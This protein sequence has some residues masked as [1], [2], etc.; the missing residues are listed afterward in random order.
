[1]FVGDVARP[2]LAVD[3]E[4]GARGL[5]RSLG[6]LLELADDVEVW[7]G[8]IGGSLCGGGG[9]S[10]KPASTIGFERRHN[11]FAQ[12]EGEEAFVHA[13]TAE[14]APQPPNF[15]RIVELNRAGP[16]SAPAVLQPLAPSRVQRAGGRRRR[17]ARR[18]GAA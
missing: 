4:E 15:E 7:P 3:P 9:T 13:L 1:M 12:I 5:H 16:P 10:E 8:H 2:D 11:R 14:L 18:T 6:R 17:R